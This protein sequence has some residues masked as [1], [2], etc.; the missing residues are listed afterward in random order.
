M[1]KPSQPKLAPWNEIMLSTRARNVLHNECI[2]TTT[3]LRNALRA[4]RLLGA[5]NCG[6]VTYEELAVASGLR[7]V[8]EY[9][10][11]RR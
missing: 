2:T 1:G 3:E 6:R 7:P 4:G 9:R 5:L 11:P 8:P 10:P